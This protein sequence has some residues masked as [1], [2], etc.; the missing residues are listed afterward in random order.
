MRTL[1]IFLLILTFIFSCK[2]K[3]TATVPHLKI[4]TKEVDRHS[5]VLETEK[6]FDTIDKN[7]II[8]I[9]MN[10]GS[11]KSNLDCDSSEIEEKY[12][13]F[14]KEDSSY[15]QKVVDVAVYYPTPLK[16]NDIINLYINLF[17]ELKNERIKNFRTMQKSQILGLHSIHKNYIFV[18]EQNHPV[19][20]S[21]PEYDFKKDYADEKNASYE[22]NKNLKLFKIDSLLNSEIDE[23]NRQNAFSFRKCRKN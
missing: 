11:R 8:Y 22:Y 23:L 15:I 6:D 19:T 2:T 1:L 18:V 7:Y 12:I 21:F 10:H 20:I 14:K 5:F 16:S 3:T 13:L 17:S 4:Q 9:K